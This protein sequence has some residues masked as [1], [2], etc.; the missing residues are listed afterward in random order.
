MTTRSQVGTRK[1]NPRYVAVATTAPISPI[2]KSV[3]AALRDPNWRAAMQAEFDA[4]I[5]NQTWELVPRPHG[6]HVV[7]G[8]WIFRHKYKDDGTL[9]RYK[10]P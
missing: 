1:P 7:S 4:L 8:K 6:T 10:A 5:G 2:P 3:H 9:D